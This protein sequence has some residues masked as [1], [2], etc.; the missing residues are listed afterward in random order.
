MSTKPFSRVLWVVLDGFGFE[1]ARR[2]IAAGA[3]PSL[4]RIEREGHLGP[5]Q[6]ARPVCQTPPALLALFTGAE[7]ADSGVWGYRMPDPA[8]AE[9]S[10]SGF[11]ADL[12]RTR[13]I[14]HELESRGRQYSLMNVAFRNDP[15]W[16]GEARHLAFG[17]DGY[18]LWKRPSL[19]RLRRG[20][21]SIEHCG[22]RLQAFASRSGLQLAKGST[23]IAR[24]EPGEGRLIQIT[25][26]VA[27]F[28]HLVT[29]DL[30]LVSPMTTTVRR[31]IMAGPDPDAG[32]L[33]MSAFH[34]ARRESAARGPAEQIPVSSELLPARVSFTRGADLMRAQAARSASS[35]VVGYFPL[36]DDFNHAWFDVFES[37]WPEGRASELFTGCIRLVDGFIGSLMDLM[38]DDTLLVVSSDH[39]AMAHRS[40][41]HL[42]EL[43]AEAGLARRGPGGY[44]FRRS[45]LWYH[46]SECGQVVPGGAAPRGP[47][48]NVALL[49][50]LR[51]VIDGANTEL[52]AGI[53][54]AEGPRN[55]PSLAFLYPFGDTYFS[56]KPPRRAGQALHA[57][58]AGGHHL[59]PLSPTPWI[60]AVIGVWGKRPVPVPPGENSDVKSYILRIMELI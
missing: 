29:S 15:V 45:A 19:Y 54:I 52:K 5:T 32:F 41:L 56:A 28:A 47:E 22:T 10:M 36:I 12:S 38:D 58:R 31:G 50:A 8:R 51:R 35:L 40:I 33:E 18:R 7:P 26:G 13:A 30:L 25:P 1:H 59:S 3:C 2:A 20:T 43:F 23:V 24:I 46:Q 44:D 4:Q 34:L 21:Q 6:P 14:W 9:R 17:Y 16:R 39:G 49:P 11:H 48:T 37:Q 55:T 60:Q 57:G 27:S 53:G 42:N